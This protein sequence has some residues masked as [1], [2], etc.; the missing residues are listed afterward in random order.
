ML[1]VPNSPNI[2]MLPPLEIR[3][4]KQTHSVIWLHGLGADGYDFQPI[5]AQFS[6]QL[7]NVGFVLPHAP[8]MPVSVNDGMEM[9]AW[10]DIYPSR[11]QVDAAGI[12]KSE[13]TVASLIEQEHA[14]GIKYS[15][16]MLAGFSQGGVIALQTALC[17]PQQ[18]AGVLALST[19]LPTAKQIP[20]KYHPANGD[21]PIFMAHG[22][23][24]EVIPITAA[25]SAY[26]R[27]K[28]LDYPITWQQY[29]ISHTVS[30]N[31][32]TDLA[33]FMRQVLV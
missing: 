1:F 2:P 22:T 17:Y 20:T 26:N 4:P 27:L 33:K 24:D 9:P 32:V 16:I 6:L 10:F 13:A 8:K 14:R 23:Y 5:V 15:N 19:Y 30:P 25:Q 29:P 12:A 3:P 11:Q 28:S 18:L 7:G 21:L 31:E